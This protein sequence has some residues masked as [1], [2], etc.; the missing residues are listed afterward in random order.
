M[1]KQ[2]LSADSLRCDR[3]LNDCISWYAATGGRFDNW[4]TDLADLAP[5]MQIH[6][7]TPDAS[8]YLYCGAKSAAAELFGTGFANNAQGQ[9]GVPDQTFEGRLN[10]D[11]WRILRD[12]SPIYQVVDAPIDVWGTR[13]GITYYRFAFPVSLPGIEAV[14][15]LTRFAATPMRLN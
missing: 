14:G 6:K 11:Y 3:V 9:A 10:Q 4:D 1:L 12:R 7:V 13:Y 2:D 8:V 15:L 5:Y